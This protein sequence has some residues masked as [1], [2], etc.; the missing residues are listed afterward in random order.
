MKFTSIKF[1]KYRCFEDEWAGFDDTK[2]IT[3]I[4]GRNNVGKSHLLHLV[5]WVCDAN[6][7]QNGRELYV[8]GVLDEKSLLEEFPK[9]TRNYDWDKNGVYFEGQQVIAELKCNVTNND[10]R[11]NE[12]PAL[13]HGVNDE[14]IISVRRNKIGNIIEKGTHVFSGLTFRRLVADRDIKT[15]V[16][17]TSLK[18]GSDGAGATNIIRRFINSSSDEYPRELVQKKLLESLNQIFSDDGKFTEILIKEHDALVTSSQNELNQWEVYLGEQH[19]K[20][21]PLSNSGS[22]L[23]TVILVLLNLLVVPHIENKKKDVYVYAFEELENNLHPAL[24]RRLLRYLERYAFENHV[25]IFLTTHSSTALDLFGSSQR[26]QIVSVSHDGKSARTRTVSAHFDKLNLIAELGAKPSD[27]LQANGIIWVEGPS[28][29]V[30]INRWIDLFSDGKWREGRDYQCAFYGG[31]LLARTQVADPQKADIELV[32]LL[33]VNPNLVVV[34]DGDRTAKTG[35]GSLLKERVK[36]IK[37]QV[38][39]IPDAG[40]WITEAKEIENYLPGV[41]LTEWA[42]GKNPTDPGKYDRFFPT[43]ATNGNSYLE[44]SLKRKSL[45]KM[46]LALKTSPLMTTELM[47]T[48]FD[49][50]KQMNVIIE[51]I[52]RWNH[53]GSMPT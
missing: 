30:Y 44:T 47:G 18:L 25:H 10:I 14:R 11:I 49:L 32:N 28:D 33:Q 13:H 46:E 34:C 50:E 1:R 38:D 3:V 48:R 22:G 37:E 43:M 29:R 15:E 12:F 42:S 26:A 17:N 35:K 4:I 24:L 40:I 20:P 23:K 19:K 53:E 8:S 2:P 31:A 41:L 27:L 7:F 6:L 5:E 9:M 16:A 52:A 45:D 21:I 39:A 51:K 36:F